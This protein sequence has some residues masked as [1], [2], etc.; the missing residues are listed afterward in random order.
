V[1]SE[2]HRN[3]HVPGSALSAVLSGYFDSIGVYRQATPGQTAEAMAW[4]ERIN[5]RRKAR[6][7]FRDLDFAD[8]RL[9][10]IARALIKLPRLLILDEPTQGLDD[11]N[12]KAVLDFIE[13][14][15]GENISTILYV[16]HRED[17]FRDFFSQHIRMGKEN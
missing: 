8:Q 14:I 3:Y 16:S 10:L 13:A 6:T 15:A 2:L 12:R 5:M 11:L 1:G 7:S 9:V 4:L 17:E